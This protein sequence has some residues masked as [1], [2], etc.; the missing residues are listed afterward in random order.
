MNPHYQLKKALGTSDD[1]D[2][3]GWHDSLVW[4]MAAAEESFEFALDLDYIFSGLL[5]GFEIQVLLINGGR[6]GT[7]DLHDKYVTRRLHRRYGWS[8]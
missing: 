5:K 4:A 7:F 3:M 2:V 6:Y 1:F 8:V